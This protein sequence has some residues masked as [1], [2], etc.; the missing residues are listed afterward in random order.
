M[1]QYMIDT[2]KVL[3]N[4]EINKQLR[5]KHIYI[6]TYSTFTMYVNRRHGVRQP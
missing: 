3:K 4:N 5:E 1:I 2:I 6:P